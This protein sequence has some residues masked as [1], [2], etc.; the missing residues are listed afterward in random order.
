M[1]RDAINCVSIIEPWNGMSTLDEME[2]EKLR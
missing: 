2:L 1:N